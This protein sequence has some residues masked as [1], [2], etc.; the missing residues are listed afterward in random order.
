MLFIVIGVFG[1]IS[2]LL[3]DLMSLNKQVF[4]KYFFA[5]FG[6]SLIVYSTIELIALKENLLISNSF[7]IISLLFAVFFMAL[8][9]YSVFIEVGGNTYKKIA[10]PRLVTN[11]T[12]SL[13]RH[14]GV[15][16]LF[17][18]IFF[19]AVFEE[20]SYLLITAFAWTFTNTLYVVF[21][22]KF[23][24]VRIFPNY[25]EYIKTTPMIIPNYLSLKK[26]ATTKNW[27]KE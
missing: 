5:L 27:R 26:F 4:F 15:I 14:P 20:N 9:I 7:R 24:L 10:E 12:Y 8:L 3:F 2:L 11:G 6:L 13:V 21:Q 22:E 1:F 18:A 17:L 19:L 25:S 16:W 23:V